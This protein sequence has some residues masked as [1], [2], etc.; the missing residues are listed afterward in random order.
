MK[1][2]AKGEAF[3]YLKA[4]GS[5]YDIGKAKGEALSLDLADMWENFTLPRMVKWYGT[6]PEKYDATYKWLR[7][8]LE[9]V[10]PY[11]VEQLVGMADG[12]GLSL[13]QVFMISHYGLLWASKGID[14]AVLSDMEACSSISTITL[15]SG[16][17][18]A[19]NLEIGSDDLYFVE[20]LKPQSG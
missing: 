18:L 6:P 14:D 5:D 10:A 13:E 8:N 17:I 20:H 19:Q 9:Q 1:I 3:Y 12:A 15:D 2:T 4:E 11:M 7:K 16:P